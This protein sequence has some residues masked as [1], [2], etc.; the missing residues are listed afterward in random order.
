MINAT[1]LDF[2]VNSFGEE[3]A[4]LVCP[5]CGKTTRE[6]VFRDTLLV[7]YPLHCWKCNKVFTIGYA[8][9][10]EKVT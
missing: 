5:R 8:G 4:H 10:V 2:K 7:N 9:G 1:E 3:K 6:K